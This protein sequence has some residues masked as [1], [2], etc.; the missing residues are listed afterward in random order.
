MDRVLP[1]RDVVGEA[2]TMYR[3]KNTQCANCGSGSL[4]SVTI[5][6]GEHGSDFRG[7]CPLCGIELL[8]GFITD[9]SGTRVSHDIARTFNPIVE[10]H[11]YTGPVA[12][13]TI[14]GWATDYCI[15]VFFNGSPLERNE[16]DEFYEF[17]AYVEDKL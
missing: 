12:P 7:T 1:Q 17:V 8:R 16:P 6:R 15:D 10:N 4:P 14:S 3:D 13:E 5:E 2:Q 11:R 9:D